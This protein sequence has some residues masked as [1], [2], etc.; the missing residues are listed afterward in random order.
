MQRDVPW[1]DDVRVL[2]KRWKQFYPRASMSPAE[3]TNAIVRLA[4]YITAALY[5][6]SRNVKYIVFGAIA[7]AVVSFLHTNEPPLRP[8]TFDALGGGAPPQAVRTASCKKSTPQ[9][10]FANFLVGDDPN[11]PPACPYDQQKDDIRTNFNRGLFRD[12]ADIYEKHNSQRQFM[13]MPVTTKIPDTKAF[14]EFLTGG[15]SRPTCKED[16]TVCTGYR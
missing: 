13:M 4:A 14:A 8:I 11:S 7:V 6:Y 2:S 16:P 10:P 3:R 5:L 12:A 9:N 1:Y 15:P